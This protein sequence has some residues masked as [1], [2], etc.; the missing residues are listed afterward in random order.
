[1]DINM[2]AMPAANKDLRPLALGEIIDR[3]KFIWAASESDETSVVFGFGHLCP[4][5]FHNLPGDYSQL[6][7]GFDCDP[8]SFT[9]LSNFIL[10]AESFVDAG[11]APDEN[12]LAYVMTRDTAV[13]VTNKPYDGSTAIVDLF[14]DRRLDQVVLLTAYMHVWPYADG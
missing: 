6:A 1:M 11:L 9:S 10:L 12:S 2:T 7:L 4:A 14:Y 8:D 13:W 3:L 5:E